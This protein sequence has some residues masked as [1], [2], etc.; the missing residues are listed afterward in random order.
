MAHIGIIGA[1][2]VGANVAFFAAERNLGDILLHDVDEGVAT[3]K[4]LDLMEAAPIRGY[5]YAIHPAGSAEELRDTEVVVVAAG[6]GRQPGMLRE[7]LYARNAQVIDSCAETLAGYTGVVI[8]ATE[9]VDPMV[10]RFQERSGLPWQRVLGVGGA[11]NSTR[12][13]HIISRRL[14]ITAESITATVIGRHSNQMIPLLEYTRV[15]GVPATVLLDEETQQEVIRETREAGDLIVDMSQR[16]SSYYGPSA[17]TT[18]II[19]A[20]VWNTHRILCPSF[21]WQG[22]YGV[23]GV[24]MSLPAV[25]GA[26][27]VERVLEPRVSA[28]NSATL[29]ESAGLLAELQKGK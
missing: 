28:E 4:A 25:I 6:V 10:V 18:D 14:G 16:A 21:V 3:G 17:A 2:N 20:V 26:G 12:L 22:H 19:Q 1:G 8:I 23:S 15:N 24:A 13:R 7:D 11:L 29:R 5:Q 27:G 9:P